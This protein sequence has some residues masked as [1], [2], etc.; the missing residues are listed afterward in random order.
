MC[1][2]FL[3]MHSTSRTEWYSVRV[4]E[5]RF[6]LVRF[7][8]SCSNDGRSTTPSYDEAHNKAAAGIAPN[9]SDRGTAWCAVKRLSECQPMTDDG[10]GKPG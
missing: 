1:R 2:A 6:S 3:Q 4:K 8:R 9:D 10:T 7:Q 5:P